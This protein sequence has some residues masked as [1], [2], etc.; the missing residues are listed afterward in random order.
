IEYGIRAIASLADTYPNIEYN[1]IG[2]GE[3]REYFQQLIQELNVSHRV[4]LLGWKQ[5]EELIEILDRSHILIAPSVTAADGNQDAPVNTLKEA[6]AMGLPV[7][8]THHGG[9]PELIEEGISG[10]LVPERDAREI[11]EKVRYLIDHPEIWP[12]MGKAGRKRVETQYNMEQLN[13]EL[14]EI[15]QQVLDRK[16]HTILL[17]NEF[18]SK[19]SIA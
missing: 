14:V 16:N 9:I 13:D 17:E 1:I 3:L 6:M 2:D 11:A 19:L 10:F 4:K 15:Y 5:Q 18:N 12:E 8:G 7:I